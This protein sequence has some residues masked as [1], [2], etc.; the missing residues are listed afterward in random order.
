MV[1]RVRRAGAFRTVVVGVLALL[2]GSTSVVIATGG[3]PGSDGRIQGCYNQVNGNL[4]V[5]TS[6]LDCRKDELSISWSQTGPQGLAG[7]TGATGAKGDTGA[8]GANGTNGTN[9]ATGATGPTGDTGPTG[10]TGATGLSGATGATGPTGATGATGPTGAT[11]AT[12]AAGPTGASGASGASGAIGL[13]GPSGASG[14]SGAAGPSGP[15]GSTGPTGASGAS[16]VKGDPCL[17]SDPACVGPKGDTGA[18]GAGLLVGA[19]CTT[20]TGQPGTVALTSDNA[21]R[22]VLTAVLTYIA[23]TFPAAATVDQGV[24]LTATAQDASH[25]TLTSY[26]AACAYTN[27]AALAL[28]PVTCGSFVNG[29]STTSVVFGAPGSTMLTVTTGGLSGT[30]G[31][32]TVAAASSCTHET[33]V[34]GMTYQLCVPLGV[35]GNETTYT[36]TMAFAAADAVIAREFSLTVVSRSYV[37]CGGFGAVWLKMTL[38]YYPSPELEVIWQYAGPAAGRVYAVGGGYGAVCPTTFEPTWN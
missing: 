22:C 34:G 17:S 30:S 14:A 26:N 20:F 10:A 8:T 35:P 6:S 25:N 29:V 24:T 32:I 4:R 1:A 38:A 9:G 16:G 12:G 28:T 5:V 31:A 37:S 18:T 27:T 11:G 33:G 7:P 13:Q 21:F 19:P 23:V 36:E 2:I 3:I 15:Q